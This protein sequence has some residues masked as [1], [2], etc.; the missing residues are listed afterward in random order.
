LSELDLI[1]SR[2][3]KLA[4]MRSRGVDPYPRGFR[5]SH[6]I[7]EV[8]TCHA[9]LAAG[10]RTENEVRVAGR[11]LTFRKMGKLVFVDVGDR[12]GRIQLYVS[13]EILGD[14]GFQTFTTELDLGDIVGAWG[15]VMT[16]RKG[17][18]SVELIGFQVL[19]KAL[20]PPPR[21]VARLEGC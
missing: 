21:E 2:R 5:R 13:R 6:T 10:A 7:G 15:T 9:Q 17:E 1:A 18:L 19:A 14:E 3:D 12:T 11:V 20:R 4:R 16:T 8:R